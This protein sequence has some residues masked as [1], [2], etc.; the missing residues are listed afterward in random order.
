MTGSAT[1]TIVTSRTMTSWAT[2]MSASRALPLPVFMVLVVT[3]A[4]YG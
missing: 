3:S 1:A 4:R 2:Q